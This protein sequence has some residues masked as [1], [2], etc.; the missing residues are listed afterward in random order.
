MELEFGFEPVSLED[1]LLSYIL[2]HFLLYKKLNYYRFHAENKQDMFL[3]YIR[4]RGYICRWMVRV[5]LTGGSIYAKIWRVR[6]SQTLKE[7]G[8]ECFK[9]MGKYKKKTLIL[10][11]V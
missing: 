8:E 5:Y 4:R 1:T 10:D 2:Y 11:R 7:L 3:V 6:G 9:H